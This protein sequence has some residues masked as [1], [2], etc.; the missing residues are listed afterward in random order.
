MKGERDV[1]SGVWVSGYG[2]G[3]LLARWKENKNLIMPRCLLKHSK[4][5]F[6]EVIL[7]INTKKYTF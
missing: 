6:C 2:R 7:H 3:V 4:F 1:P 5:L